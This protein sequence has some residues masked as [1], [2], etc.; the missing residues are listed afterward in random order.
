M[1]FIQ[2][3]GHR[4]GERFI[5]PIFAEIDE[6][7]LEKVSEYQWSQNSSSNPNT[8]YAISTTGGKRTHLHRLIMGLGDFKKDKRVINHKDGNGLNN[9]KENLEICDTL[10]NSQSFRRPYGNKGC[11]HF[12]TSMK[13]KKRWEANIVINKV[14]YR[15]RFLTENE[16]KQYIEEWVERLAE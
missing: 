16:A 6:D 8:I 5:E 14:R 12:D 11:I 3:G 1:P 10:Y 9:K 7:D 2:V 13:R 4:G 15:K